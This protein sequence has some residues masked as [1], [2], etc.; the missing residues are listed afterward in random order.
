MLSETVKDGD[1]FSFPADRDFWNNFVTQV[2]LYPGAMDAPHF[3]VDASHTDESVLVNQEFL[4]RFVSGW[5]TANPHVVKVSTPE[6]STSFHASEE[7]WNRFVSI[8]G[9]RSRERAARGEVVD[10]NTVVQSG[11]YPGSAPVRTTAADWRDICQTWEVEKGVTPEQKMQQM[12]QRWQQIS[13]PSSR[14]RGPEVSPLPGP[15]PSD[16]LLMQQNVELQAQRNDLAHKS[17]QLDAQRRQLEDIQRQLSDAQRQAQAANQ[18]SSQSMSDLQQ[19]RS[20]ADKYRREMEEL[21]SSQNQM[22][23]GWDRERNALEDRLRSMEAALG[24][25]QTD[26]SRQRDQA[27]REIQTREQELLAVKQAADI[28]DLKKELQMRE[29]MQEEICKAREEAQREAEERVRQEQLQRTQQ[30]LE[31]MRRMLRE[32]PL[33]G[34]R[35]STPVP[36]MAQCTPAA[37]SQGVQCEPPGALSLSANPAYRTHGPQATQT[38]TAVCPPSPAHR[39]VT[40]THCPQRTVATQTPPRSRPD[41]A[42]S[43]PQPP[44]QRGAVPAQGMQSMV[45]PQFPFGRPVLPPP[46][47]GNADVFGLRPDAP[48][49]GGGA[50]VPVPAGA[51]RW[52]Q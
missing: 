8:A 38:Q 15:D 20:E 48:R 9:Q 11:R 25:L 2:R 40:V 4:R 31:D 19:A 43:Y 27:Q 10:E 7:F 51:A 34:I 35:G 41:G 5:E 13:D 46:D 3:H 32:H 18:R 26:V 28:A 6:G 39:Y 49:Y 36:A 50:P 37:S 16:A 30:E 42:H 47:V 17:S 45:T 44:A 33:G 21:R 24:Q 22:Q 52:W 14:A 23:Q 12:Q 29:L 1:H